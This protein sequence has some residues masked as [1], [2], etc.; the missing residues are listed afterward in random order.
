MF[1]PKYIEKSQALEFLRRQEMD[2]HVK[3]MNH[4]GKTN[5]A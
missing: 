3:K 4:I 1:G 2:A 5:I